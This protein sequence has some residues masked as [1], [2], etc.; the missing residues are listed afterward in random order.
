MK[1]D[2]YL[3]LRVRPQATPEQI[4]LA[5][6]QRAL[7]LHPDLWGLD[8]A[9]FLELQEAYSVLSDPAR[10]AAYDGQTEQCP[11]ARAE[12][13][14]GRP[15]RA[16]QRG[17]A[18]PLRAV[19]P[20]A[21]FADVSLSH[22]FD[23]F[24]PA[25][26]ELFDWLWSN[27]DLLTRPKAEELRSLT[28][29][30]PLSA[31]QALAGGEVRILVPTRVLCSTCRGRGRAGPYECWR[32]EGRG[33]LTGEYPVSVS[34]PAGLRQDYVV[35]LPLEL[36]IRNFYLTLRFRRTETAGLRAA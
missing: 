29:D 3:A 30:V 9:P 15:A 32:C 5:Y 18:E 16:V 17:A 31:Q 23:T 19:G 4:K 6:K 13:M 10:R 24:Q 20:A 27:F 28:V 33:A 36:G 35:R 26:D 12:P 2:Y 14:R 1:K 11:V 34:Y 25:F 21:S 7:E 8:S 22:A